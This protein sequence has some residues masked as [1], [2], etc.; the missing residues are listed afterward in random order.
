MSSAD[1]SRLTAIV[2]TC[3]RPAS[4]ERLAKSVRR[5]YPQLRLLVA[6]DSRQPR[7]VDDAGLAEIDCRLDVAAARL[8]RVARPG[9]AVRGSAHLPVA[10]G[11][12]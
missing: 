1:L 11:G 6:D 9:D 5:H 7:P 2:R 10:G 4:V 8:G 12:L 3:E